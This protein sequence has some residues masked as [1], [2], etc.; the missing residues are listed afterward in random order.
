MRFQQRAVIHE[1]LRR[2][3]QITNNLT[4]QLTSQESQM[5]M[6]ANDLKNSGLRAQRENLSQLQ[7]H[8][9]IMRKYYLRKLRY[10]D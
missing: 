2:H 5:S 3:R 7:V 10:Q 8:R 1:V 6:V 4:S 9:L